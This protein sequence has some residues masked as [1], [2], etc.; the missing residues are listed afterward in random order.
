MSGEK[1]LDLSF[2]HCRLSQNSLETVSETTDDSLLNS[3]SS[4]SSSDADSL[5]EDKPSKEDIEK[6]FTGLSNVVQRG[7]HKSFVSVDDTDFDITVI[8][9]VVSKPNLHQNLEAK[10]DLLL[11]SAKLKE[12]EDT[13]SGE[14]VKTQ[15]KQLHKDSK[16]EDSST[17]SDD[18]SCASED[19]HDRGENNTIGKEDFKGSVSDSKPFHQGTERKC[20]NDPQI[21]VDLRFKDAKHECSNDIEKYQAQLSESSA[22]IKKKIK[23]VRITKVDQNPGDR[24]DQGKSK[25][26]QEANNDTTK[27]GEILDCSKKLS[28]IRQRLHEIINETL[29]VKEIKAKTCSKESMVF[30]N[31]EN[32]KIK[33]FRDIIK[34]ASD[35]KHVCSS[36]PIQ[37]NLT[38]KDLETPPR[39]QKIPIDFKDL[40]LNRPMNLCKKSSMFGLQPWNNL[41]IMAKVSL[42]RNNLDMITNSLYQKVVEKSLENMLERLDIEPDVDDENCKK[43]IPP[44][45]KSWT[46]LKQLFKFPSNPEHLERVTLNKPTFSSFE[47]LLIK[48]TPWMKGGVTKSNQPIIKP[49]KL[50][51]KEVEKK[52]NVLTK[53]GTKTRKRKQENHVRFA[54]SFNKGDVT[55]SKQPVIKPPK[56]I[57]KVKNA[58][59]K[60][61]VGNI[62]LSE[63]SSS[64]SKEKNR[65]PVDSKRNTVSEYSP[66]PNKRRKQEPEFIGVN[67]FYRNR[68]CMN[69]KQ[70]A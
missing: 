38:G 57:K 2:N 49:S 63:N 29:D 70:R 56:L 7:L 25:Q 8:A 19:V 41:D 61:K 67:S 21:G 18:S 37:G 24:S 12:I 6:I 60:T 28:N 58:T 27:K 11:G 59:T 42:Q 16:N 65:V 62:S 23:S 54:T 33:E 66:S 50:V 13:K 40:L 35:F 51:I 44:F 4:Y 15:H 5:K 32:G 3:S 20:N 36:L 30:S 22:E 10:S 26:F 14:E 9:N 69:L 55:K 43:V 39:R 17:E 46:K 53:E 1:A 31:L 45:N 48:N 64:W 47:S 52:P 68:F 34:D